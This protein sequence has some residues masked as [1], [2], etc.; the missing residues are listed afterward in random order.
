L[1]VSFPFAITPCIH[2]TSHTFATRACVCVC[3]VHCMPLV[4]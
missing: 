3:V 1:F 4:L 2:V